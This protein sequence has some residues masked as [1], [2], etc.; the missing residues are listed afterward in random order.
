MNVKY[1]S[2]FESEV[3]YA[4]RTTIQDSILGYKSLKKCQQAPRFVQKVAKAVIITL[5]C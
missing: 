3:R 5:L 2:N 4:L 1:S